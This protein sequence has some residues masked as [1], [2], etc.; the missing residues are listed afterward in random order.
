MVMTPQ[1]L[2]QLRLNQP[3][4]TSAEAEAQFRQNWQALTGIPSVMNSDNSSSTGHRLKEDSPQQ[5]KTVHPITIG[6][7]KRGVS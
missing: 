6:F 5:D 3:R 1:Q 7:F 4:L 2:R